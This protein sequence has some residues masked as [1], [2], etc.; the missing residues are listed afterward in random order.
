M[1]RAKRL[2]MQDSWMN[3]VHWPIE[4]NELVECKHTDKIVPLISKKGLADFRQRVNDIIVTTLVTSSPMHLRF[5]GQAIALIIVILGFVCMTEEEYVTGAVLVVLGLVL[6]ALGFWYRQQLI[7]RAWKKIGQQ[8]SNVFKDMGDQWAGV[9][10]EF[11]VQGMHRTKDERK[12]R[13]TVFYERYIIIYLPGDAS[14]FHD[15][16]EDKRSVA[17]IVKSDSRAVN[18]R[19]DVIDDNPLTLPYWWATATTDDG[20][21]YFINNLKH[22][23]QWN[24]PT[25]DQIEMEKAELNEVLAPPGNDNED[26]YETDSDESS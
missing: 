22:R 10:Y 25:M 19:Q 7:N 12:E 16:V 21:T 9:S 6:V 26:D 3:K 15:Y 1:S 14:N 4:D 23:T 8:L 11:H 5:G 20:K 2:K 24:P 13:R 18:E 17:A